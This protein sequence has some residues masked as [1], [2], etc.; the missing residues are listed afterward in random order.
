MQNTTTTT[1]VEEPTTLV[2]IQNTTTSVEEP[3]TLVFICTFY[4]FILGS[5]YYY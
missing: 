4:S 1:S 3:T 5:S 2:F